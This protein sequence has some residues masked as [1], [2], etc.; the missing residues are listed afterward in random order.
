MPKKNVT[1]AEGGNVSS[2]APNVKPEFKNIAVS[3]VVKIKKAR[4]KRTPSVKLIS[5]SMKMVIPTGPYANIQPEIIVKAGT[6]EAAHDFIAPHMNK[7]WKEYYMCSE[8]RPEPP[9]TTPV[10]PPVTPS[11][12]TPPVAEQP[13]V[14]SVAL[15][16]ATQA[17][18]SCLSLEAFELIQ[19]QVEKSVKLTDEDKKSLTPLLDSKLKELKNGN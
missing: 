7:L 10:A 19:N 13:P 17:I 2:T 3:P 15:L 8:R 14:S 1:P 18:Q 16:K 9:K 5:Y 4:K 11:V 12:V 6:V